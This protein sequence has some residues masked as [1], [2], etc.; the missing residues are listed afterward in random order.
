MR[1][2]EQSVE[3]ERER[4]LLAHDREQARLRA[5]PITLRFPPN[6]VFQKP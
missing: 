2:F 5:E 3:L 4:A 6:L 1:D